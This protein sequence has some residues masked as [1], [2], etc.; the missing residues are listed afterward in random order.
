VVFTGEKNLE[1]LQRG[2]ADLHSPGIQFIERTRSLKH[3][4]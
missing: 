4:K 1:L 2:A 3:M